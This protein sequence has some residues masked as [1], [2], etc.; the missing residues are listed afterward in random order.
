MNAW[1][2]GDDCVTW[3]MHAVAG[4][5]EDKYHQVTI[6]LLLMTHASS[7]HFLCFTISSPRLHSPRESHLPDFLVDFASR[8]S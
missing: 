3:T 4:K 5:R 1:T 2:A 7:F 6:F 8:I